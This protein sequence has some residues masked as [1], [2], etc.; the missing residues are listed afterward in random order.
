MAFSRNFFETDSR[1]ASSRQFTSI[2]KVSGSTSTS[3]G[4]APVSS[5]AATVATA[6]CETV[7]T[8][9]PGPTSQARKA[10]AIASVPFPT[11]TTW[12]APRNAANSFSNAATSPPKIY[13]PLSSARAM[14]LRISASCARKFAF[15]LL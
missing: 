14:A 6:V 2:V 5:I 3:T 4:E 15:G 11:P 1:I 9:S 8:A 12:R 13:Q 10:S 7:M